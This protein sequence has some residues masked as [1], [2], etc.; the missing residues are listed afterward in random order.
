VEGEGPRIC[1]NRCVFC[2]VDQN[3][4]GVRPGLRV[5]DDD[6]RHSFLHGTY[7]TLEDDQV[8]L[9]LNRRLSP[10]YVSVH[11]TD[12]RL[13]GQMLGRRA[14]VPVVPGL[15]RLRM[16]GIEVRGQ[17]V[18]VPG[19]NDGQA[20]KHTVSTLLERR[21]VSELGVV[22]VGLTDH[23]QGLPELRR[24][25]AGESSQVLA[26]CLEAGRWATDAG[27]G[28][29]IWPADEF[30]IMAGTEIPDTRFYSGCHLREN[31]IGM[32]ASLADESPSPRGSGTV[33][34][35]VLAAPFLR[36]LLAGSRYAV[37][38]AT[39]DFFGPKVGVAGLLSG[40]D[41][42]SAIRGL[43]EAGQAGPFFLPSVMFNCDSLTLDDLTLPDIVR[44]VGAEVLVAESLGDLP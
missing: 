23:R 33:V 36:G 39:N 7:V 17:V 40:G 38:T 12:P 3:P 32:L 42:V 31:G 25:T 6:I 10:V 22:P 29:W 4:P 34:T 11:T 28:R 44:A 16:E 41:V 5:R 27:L 43:L 9:A 2:F 19:L 24:P 21:L 14:P 26:L 30:L 35:G 8:E 18:V 15:E 13:R 37:A 1:R 20:L